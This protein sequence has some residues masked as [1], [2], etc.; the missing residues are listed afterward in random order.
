VITL[1]RKLYSKSKRPAKG[2][3][4]TQNFFACHDCKRRALG[5]SS[6]LSKKVSS[7]TWMVRFGRMIL[8]VR[9]RVRGRLN[10][11][12]SIVGR[13]G[14]SKL[15]YAVAIIPSWNKAP[16]SRSDS[17]KILFHSDILD[18]SSSLHRILYTDLSV[19][20]LLLVCV[21]RYTDT[22]A[23]IHPVL[24]S[25]LNET[26]RHQ[27]IPTLDPVQDDCHASKCLQGTCIQFVVCMKCF[28]RAFY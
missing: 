2:C 13:P 8:W 12:Y 10:H 27:I 25:Q 9:S 14:G 22:M 3:S 15:P 16:F 28:E 24:K 21:F 1:P 23:E 18:S 4:H 17:R 7:A 6:S 11:I 26:Y 20:S 5:E 19:C